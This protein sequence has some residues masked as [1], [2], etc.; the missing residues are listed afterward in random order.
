MPKVGALHARAGFM[1]TEISNQRIHSPLAASTRALRG[2]TPCCASHDCRF[3][4]ASFSS[5]NILLRL[6]ASCSCAV[7][8]V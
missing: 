1:R 4:M 2:S 7:I 8:C 6:L 5:S 3:A